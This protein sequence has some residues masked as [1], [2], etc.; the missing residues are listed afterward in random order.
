M[1]SPARPSRLA[2]AKATDRISQAYRAT[3]FQNIF[4]TQDSTL[5]D[6]LH[7]D[8]PLRA[9]SGAQ[10]QPLVTDTAITPSPSRQRQRRRRLIQDDDD[11]DDDNTS[12]DQD[13]SSSQTASQPLLPILPSLSQHLGNE[14]E[15]LLDSLE[16]EPDQ[17]DWSLPVDR[18]NS[19]QDKA[20]AKDSVH[21][22]SSRKRTRKILPEHELL[23][24]EATVEPTNLETARSTSP[25][26][27]TKSKKLKT[28]EPLL[29]F[30][31][32]RKSLFTVSTRSQITKGLDGSKENHDERVLSRTLEQ[33]QLPNRREGAMR[34]ILL[35]DNDD[36][37][38]EDDADDGED[39]EGSLTTLREEFAPL[40]EEHTQ[41]IEA[42]AI[43]AT[44]H[45]DAAAEDSE[46]PDD[47]DYSEKAEG[48]GDAGDAGDAVDAGDSEEALESENQEKAAKNEAR[49]GKSKPNS[50]SQK[51]HPRGK[52]KKSR[53]S[54][55]LPQHFHLYDHEV[56]KV[57]R[58]TGSD[59][60]N[61]AAPLY[62]TLN[63]FLNREQ[64]APRSL[65]LKALE[66]QA[67]DETYRWPVREELL[68]RVPRAS[69]VDEGTRA[70]FFEQQGMAFVEELTGVPKGESDFSDSD[71]D[72]GGGEFEQAIAAS[73]PKEL[74][75]LTEKQEKRLL[76]KYEREQAEIQEARSFGKR[77]GSGAGR[78]K[79]QDRDEELEIDEG[80]KRKSGRS[81]RI[82]G[83]IKSLRLAELEEQRRRV[84]KAVKHARHNDER[85]AQHRLGEVYGF[86]KEEVKTFA[87][88]QY[89][90]GAQSRTEQPSSG[91]ALN[92]SQKITGGEQ[93]EDH[94]RDE[95]TVLQ[96][97]ASM[98]AAEDT[99]QRVLGRLPYVIRQG[100]MGGMPEYVRLG[101]PKPM[102]VQSD[103]E[104]GWQ[105]MMTAAS[106]SG[107]DD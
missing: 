6:S 15:A 33:T 79:G 81:G 61:Q 4:G 31:A 51:K 59:F 98:F 94:D 69:F 65:A 67:L 36:D 86:F 75:K 9:R 96:E 54:L 35:D 30:E 39:D 5:E 85:K 24:S 47:P 52:P 92:D 11:D 46:D 63:S 27:P 100:A 102:S 56:A 10:E 57:V 76:R 93:I 18:T 106:L 107:V 89:R 104:R 41:K 77:A 26:S 29:H 3:I 73:L 17:L 83:E 23:F 28:T 16:Q 45:H 40:E 91:S 68:P 72:L 49:A 58:G 20:L 95:L 7:S 66:P 53:D 37:D 80:S 48:A 22:G 42:K 8:P 78:R 43:G 38:D 71:D 19:S 82:H 44:D 21:L 97:N 62:L 90:K 84:R 88:S 2:K 25:T 55:T 14:A 64:L 70:D 74:V 101:L 105:T 1:A 87:H 12:P 32:T 103:Y 50:L 13:V 99:L 34:R 60:E